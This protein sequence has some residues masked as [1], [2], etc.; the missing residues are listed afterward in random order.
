MVVSSRIA[1]RKGSMWVST[2]RD[3]VGGRYPI[4]GDTARANAQPQAIRQICGTVCDEY[5]HL[6][7]AIADPAD[8]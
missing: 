3:R 1:V 7:A 4:K 6:A 8:L 5:Q 2:S